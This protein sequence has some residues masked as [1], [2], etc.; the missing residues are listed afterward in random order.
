R[1]FREAAAQFLADKQEGWDNDD[2]RMQWYRSLEKYAYPVLGDIKVSAIELPHI[3]EVL[4]PIWTKRAETASHVRGRVERILDYARV[5][6]W[7]GG[8][9]PAR[10]RGNLQQILT[11]QANF[12]GQKHVPSMPWEHVPAFVARLRKQTTVAAKCL[13]FIILTGARSNEAREAT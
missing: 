11:S 1:T 5:H 4:K 7:C 2:H 6:G 12:K 10:W 9:N 3:L 13:E 8:E